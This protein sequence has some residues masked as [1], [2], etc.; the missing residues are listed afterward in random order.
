[1]RKWFL[2]FLSST[3]KAHRKWPIWKWTIS[4]HEDNHQMRIHFNVDIFREIVSIKVN[5]EK[6]CV[7]KVC[8]NSRFLWLI[9]VEWLKRIKN[10]IIAL[11][12]SFVKT[13]YFLMRILFALQ[14]HEFQLRFSP[15]NNINTG[16]AR[17]EIHKRNH[18]LCV[19]TSYVNIYFNRL[20][21]C[22]IFASLKSLSVLLH[23]R[24]H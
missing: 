24:G 21:S 6:D 20:V 12:V 23:A 15:T 11:S 14:P 2:V 5:S 1:M 9:L 7:I 22:S 3:P 19:Q 18:K 16:E 17:L 13:R 8:V 10:V 4:W